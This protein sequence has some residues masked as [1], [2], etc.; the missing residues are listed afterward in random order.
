MPILYRVKR[1]FALVRRTPQTNGNDTFS[2]LAIYTDEDQAHA[3]VKELSG[4]TT[5][6]ATDP[7]FYCVAAD[8]IDPRQM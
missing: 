7:Y 2:I 4:T 1:A 8:L 3:K 6:D 5:T